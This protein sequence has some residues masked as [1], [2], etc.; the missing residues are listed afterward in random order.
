M[1][2]MLRKWENK[3]DSVASVFERNAKLYPNKDAFL[4]DDTKITFKEVK[5][6]S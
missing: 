6:I 4:I 2:I 1:A 5:L 3:R